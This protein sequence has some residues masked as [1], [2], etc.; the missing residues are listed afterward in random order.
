MSLAANPDACEPQGCCYLNV[1]CQ[2]CGLCVGH[3]TCPPVEMRKQP[4]KPLRAAKRKQAKRR[5]AEYHGRKQE[6]GR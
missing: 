4:G 6:Q 2:R 3:C 1:L 5:A